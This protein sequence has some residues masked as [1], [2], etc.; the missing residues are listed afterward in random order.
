AYSSATGFTPATLPGAARDAVPSGSY[1][2]I[3]VYLWAGLAPPS[4]LGAGALLLAVP[5]MNVY[6]ASHPVP[7]RVVSAS[8]AVAA[9]DGGVGFSAALL[10][11]LAAWGAQAKEAQQKNR[12]T[13]LLNPDS[14]LYGN[15]P[16]YY[17]QNLALF[18]VGWSQ[19]RYRFGADGTLHVG[20]NKEHRNADTMG[21]GAAEVSAPNSTANGAVTK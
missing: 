7:P 10:P 1:D 15:Q 4:M 6:L 14:G 5:G 3:R 18:A 13:A 9:A 19:K 20:W 8:G 11:Y 16:H 17:A 21:S 2:A 12:L